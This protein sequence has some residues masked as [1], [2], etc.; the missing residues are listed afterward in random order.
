MTKIEELSAR[1]SEL[2]AQIT[3]AESAEE[4][5]HAD[6]INSHKAVREARAT[7]DAAVEAAQSE[8][9]KTLAEDA[10]VQSVMSEQRAHLSKLKNQLR[11]VRS[12]IEHERRTQLEEESVRRQR[13]LA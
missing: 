1:E 2:L 7:F 13:G 9:D 4:A 6:A 10:R 5:A 12:Q 11:D 8:F 3:E